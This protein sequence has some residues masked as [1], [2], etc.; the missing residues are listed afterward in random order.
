MNPP[1]QDAYRA[2]APIYD[3]GG[4]SE[5][6]MQIVQPLITKMQ[7]EGWIGRRILELGCGTG[8]GTAALAHLG[9]DI[10]ALDASPEMLHI[11]GLR[12]TDTGYNVELMQD[13][14][15]SARYPPGVDLV[16]MLGNTL[17][18]LMSLK[19][20]EAVFARSFAALSPG[21]RLVFDCFTLRGLGE[22]LGT[23]EHVLPL[24]ERLFVG[25]ENRFSFDSMTLRQ[26]IHSFR[27]Q[28]GAWQRDT[29][30]L[31]LRGYPIAALTNLLERVGFEVL[32]VY[33]VALNAIH[34]PAETEGQVIL[35][36]E[37]PGG[38]DAAL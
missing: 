35:I 32:G 12:L 38:D 34:P 26:V 27:F 16:W 23:R 13:D 10:I 6:A 29:V 14:I 30:T 8:A 21:R 2:L 24:S 15:R 9:M 19:Q 33:D 28:E 18:E 36:A 17:N 31:A 11:A 5:Y 20:I 3:D 4:F 22:E 37:K 7:S 1:N 25:I